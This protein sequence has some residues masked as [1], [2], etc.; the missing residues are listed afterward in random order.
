[1]AGRV[2]NNTYEFDA[3]ATEINDTCDIIN[4]TEICQMLKNRGVII[5]R[6]KD[7]GTR[8]ESAGW[9]RYAGKVR[10]KEAYVVFFVAPSCTLKVAQKY[11]E[12]QGVTAEGLFEYPSSTKPQNKDKASQDCRF[13]DWSTVEAKRQVQKSTQQL[14][15][16]CCDE[17]EE[18]GIVDSD[19]IRAAMRTHGLVSTSKATSRSRRMIIISR[20]HRRG[21]VTWRAGESYAFANATK[22]KQDVAAFYAKKSLQTNDLRLVDDEK[23]KVRTPA[24]QPVSAGTLACNELMAAIMRY[25]DYCRAY[26]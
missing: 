17:L 19:D 5:Q 24:E 8:L 6:A 14:T 23:K 2:T 12:P 13:R 4:R 25:R 11:C 15:D 10:D 16:Q 18:H 21:F 3:V 9:K 20:L 22:S 1:M 26:A 7:V